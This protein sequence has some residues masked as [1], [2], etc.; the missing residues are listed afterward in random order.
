MVAKEAALKEAAN[1]KLRRLLSY[2]RSFNCAEAKLGHS[3][4]SMAHLGGAS[5]MSLDALD[6]LDGVIR[7]LT[8]KT[9]LDGASWMSTKR[10]SR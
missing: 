8:V 7:R 10:G 4:P 1:S 5:W 6:A 3:T 9:H 2:N